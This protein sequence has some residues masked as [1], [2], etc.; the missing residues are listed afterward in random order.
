MAS[1]CSLDIVETAISEKE[2]EMRG[3]EEGFI[4]ALVEQ[5]QKVASML[6]STVV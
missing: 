1:A 6:Q 3:M 2:A 5:H 4:Q